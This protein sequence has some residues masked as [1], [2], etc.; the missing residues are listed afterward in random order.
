MNNP[1]P[2]TTQS[3]KTEPQPQLSA[4]AHAA[5]PK[6]EPQDNIIDLCNSSPLRPKSPLKLKLSMKRKR[7]HSIIS[8]SSSDSDG[9]TIIQHPKMSKS[10]MIITPSISLL[11]NQSMASSNGTVGAIDVSSVFTSSDEAQDAIIAYQE[12]LG[13]RWRV[14]QSKRGPDGS[15]R[16]F[17]FRCNRYYCHKPVHSPYIDPSD[18]RKGKSYKTDCDARVIINCSVNGLWAVTTVFWNHNHARELPVGAIAPRRP[19]QNQRDLVE[20]F[21]GNSG[22][23]KFGRQQVNKILLERFPDRPLKPRQISNMINAAK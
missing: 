21:S 7:S 13:H 5:Y 3:N 11:H 12:K 19:T 17:T 23:A 9:L 14:A 16:K 2:C 10:P 18:H 4:S 22:T 6:S 15:Q 20:C 1:E 8:V